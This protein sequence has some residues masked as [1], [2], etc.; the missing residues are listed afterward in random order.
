MTVSMYLQV[1]ALGVGGFLL[2]RHSS[3]PERPDYFGTWRR[4][5]RWAWALFGGRSRSIHPFRLST[6]LTMI[7]WMVAG[8]CAGLTDPQ[9]R[10][11]LAFVLG[12]SVTLATVACVLTWIVVFLG[13][14]WRRR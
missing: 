6:E 10:S 12:G 5:P 2:V 9:P 1:F 7:V 13:E 14:E 4:A 11:L 3:Q 8:L